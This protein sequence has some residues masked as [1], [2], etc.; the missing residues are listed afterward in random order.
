MRTL[1]LLIITFFGLPLIA[2]KLPAGFIRFL[3]ENDGINA[4]FKGQDWG[5]TNGTRIDYFRLQ[6]PGKTNFFSRVPFRP[7][8]EAI[9]TKGWGLMQ[10]MYA[11]KKT[12]PAIPDKKD[13]SYAGGLLAIHSTHS[14]NPVKKQFTQVEWIAGVLGPP[15]FAKQTQ[16]FIH[17]IIGDPEP[18]GWPYQLPTDLLLNLNTMFEKRITGNR[19]TD[20][21]AAAQVFAGTMQ[22]GVQASGILR[23]RSGLSFYD[24]LAS[25]FFIS[26]KKRI[27]ILLS[28]RPLVDFTLHNALLDGGLFNQRS[29]VNDNDAPSGTDL[30]RNKFTTQLDCSFLLSWRNLSLSFTQKIISPEFKGYER[31][32]VGNVSLSIGQR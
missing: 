31:H 24:G 25:R 26:E 6:A 30:A 13:Y 28:L 16:V 23:F 32:K 2:Q 20:I 7:A 8:E 4:L 15:S 9:I 18:N 3:E 21:C 17:R 29:P 1:S 5:Y 14:S 11:P 27:A 10:V 22:T 19:F 12:N